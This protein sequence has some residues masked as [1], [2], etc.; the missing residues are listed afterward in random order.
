MSS[1]QLAFLQWPTYDQC[2]T[3]TKHLSLHLLNRAFFIHVC[4]KDNVAIPWYAVKYS[5]CNEMKVAG[6]V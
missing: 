1:N 2:I 3:G 4:A 6:D 5:T